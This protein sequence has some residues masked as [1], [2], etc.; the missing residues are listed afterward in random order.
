MLKR[1]L[2]LGISLFQD[3]TVARTETD[4]TT[5]QFVRHRG[6]K[7][8]LKIIGSLY[9]LV[10]SVDAAVLYEG[11]WPY[12]IKNGEA[13]LVNPGREDG[14]T[15]YKTSMGGNI[16]F[17]TTLGGCPLVEIGD[18]FLSGCYDVTNVVIPSTVRRIGDY[19]FA[20][21]RIKSIYLPKCLNEIGDGAFSDCNQILSITI[22]DN[23]SYLGWGTLSCEQMQYVYIGSSVSNVNYTC[24]EGCPSSLTIEVSKDN[25]YYYEG[26]FYSLDQK[27]V[28]ATLRPNIGK[29]IQIKEG[30]THIADYAF[31]QAKYL[32][33][34]TFPNSLVYIGDY[35]FSSCPNLQSIRFGENVRD[36][37]EYAFGGCRS[38]KEVS[39]PNS[40]TNMSDYLFSHCYSLQKL[41]IGKSVESLGWCALWTCDSLS[42]LTVD[43]SNKKFVA[44]DNVLYSKDLKTLY[45]CPGGIENC[46]ILDSV[47]DIKS[48]AFYNSAHLKRVSI[49]DSVE[50]LRQRQFNDCYELEEV[51][52]GSGIIS[53]DYCTFEG[54]T[55][56]NKIVIPKNVTS[57]HRYAFKGCVGLQYVIFLGDAPYWDSNVL[58]GVDADCFPTAIV[59]EGSKG[60][61]CDIPGRWNGMPIEYCGHINVNYEGGVSPTCDQVGMT[62][63]GSFQTCQKYLENR[64]IP[65]LGHVEV[66]DFS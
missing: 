9:M 12:E 18:Q 3:F 15:Y 33:N 63:E 7:S 23:V 32:E 61:G 56:L 45:V 49:P 59:V 4:V 27:T 41:H 25:P 37:G 35:G 10:L 31:C 26:L 39:L 6:M 36:F 52:L 46:N 24:F 40:V 11:V 28:I 43:V 57:I 58:D 8:L 5:R 21:T 47:I 50:K 48:E 1:I 44:V 65:A 17:P 55:M 34:I 22:P 51:E 38:L 30:V 42:N 64:T 19:A 2:L 53:I 16:Q 13:Y 66:D 62:G 54:C 60:W 20:D 29:Q 14:R